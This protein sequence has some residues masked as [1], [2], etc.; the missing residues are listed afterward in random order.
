MIEII[1][2]ENLLENAACVGAY[3]QERLRTLQAHGAPICEVRGRGLM[4]GVELTHPVARTVF[5][6]ALERRLIL[7]AVGDTVLRIV[8]PLVITKRDVDEAI[9]NSRLAVFQEVS[10]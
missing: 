7:N 2:Q 3:L 9:R 8:P 4:I 1:E 5:Q 6:N 10:V